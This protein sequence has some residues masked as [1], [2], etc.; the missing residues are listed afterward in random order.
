M[1]RREFI[2]LLGGGAATW[3]F[4]GR[5]QQQRERMRRISVLMCATPED[6]YQTTYLSAF[7]QGL[8]ERCWTI[9]RNVRLDYRWGA[10]NSDSLS[11]VCNGISRARAACYFGDGRSFL[12]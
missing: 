5:A 6:P 10:G 9:G 2:T 11:E 4:T 1:R 3:P 12:I 7:M 8:Q